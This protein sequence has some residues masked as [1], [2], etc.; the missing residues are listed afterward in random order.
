MKLF[1]NVVL[2][3]SALLLSTNAIAAKPFTQGQALSQCRALANTQFED[4]TRFK[5]IHMKTKRG[6][7]K[8]K[9]RINTAN[10]RGMFLCTVERDQ[11]AQIVR[12]DKSA[13]AIA[14]K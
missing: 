14:A 3:G 1:V 11:E 10:E 9:L 12:L 4:V 8:A 13:D 6:Q 2:I 5:A 7:F